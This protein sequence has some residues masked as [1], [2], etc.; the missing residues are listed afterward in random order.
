MSKHFYFKQF[1]LAYALLDPLILSGATISGQSR[2][3]GN[4][5]VRR[6]SQH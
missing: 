1:S 3:D 4:E 5:R 6:I 2:S